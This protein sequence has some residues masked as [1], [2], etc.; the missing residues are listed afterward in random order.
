MNGKLSLLE[1]A[2]QKSDQREGVPGRR[3]RG[4]VCRFAFVRAVTAG[5]LHNECIGQ[6]LSRANSCQERDE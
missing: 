2:S 1:I 3:I 6:E 5:S 4:V